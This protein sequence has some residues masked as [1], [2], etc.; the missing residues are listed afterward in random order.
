MT[1]PTAAHRHDH[2]QAP[3]SDLLSALLATGLGI[4]ARKPIDDPGSGAVEVDLWAPRASV[5]SLDHWLGREG[6]EPF[7]APGHDPHRFYLGIREGRWCKLD[8]KLHPARRRAPRWLVA[9]LRRCPVSWRRGGPVVAFVGPDGA[10]KGTVIAGVQE[11]IPVAVDVVYLGS[12][13]SR[14]SRKSATSPTDEV[15]EPTWRRR[16]E[17]LFVTRTL[18]RQSRRL[19][20]IYAAAWRGRIVLCDRHPLEALA[21][22]PRRTR[23]ARAL[24]RFVVRHVLPWPDRVVVLDAPAEVMYRRKGEHSV[25]VLDAW[26]RGYATQ[27]AGPPRPV[28]VVDTHR[29]QHESV[30]EA[31]LV[32]WDALAERRCWAA[33]SHCAPGS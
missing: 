12:R 2:R 9:G 17:P 16:L 13:P 7:A 4:Q 21:I 25:E 33:V 29:P 18:A 28:R 32:V 19:L 14:R 1:R 22:D 30:S 15:P 11:S 24:E 31:T 8:V 10:G 26:R 5:R 3:L 23:A 27:L 6:F 20:R